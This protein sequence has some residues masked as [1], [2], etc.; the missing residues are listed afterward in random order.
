MCT[1]LAGLRAWRSNSRGAF[2]ACSSTKS[3]SRKTVWSSTFWPAWRNRSS[4]RSS[5]NS[6]PISLIS[7]RH[8]LS[9]VAIAS[10]ESTS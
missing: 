8:P 10:S 5:M 2:A 1:L 3:G 9:R 6:T 7:R 4:A